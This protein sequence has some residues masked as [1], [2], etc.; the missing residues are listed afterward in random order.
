MLVL[1]FAMTAIRRI[2]LTSSSFESGIGYCAGVYTLTCP[3]LNEAIFRARNEEN[4]KNGN[5]MDDEL[6][7]RAF[8]RETPGKS[9]GMR[10]R[11]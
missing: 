9:G 2:G 3:P 4:V 5:G 10:N 7:R 6:I 11:E 8:P 1:M